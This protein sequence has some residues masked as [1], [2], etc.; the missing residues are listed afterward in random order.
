MIYTHV[1]KG[2]APRCNSPLDTL[3]PDA[4]AQKPAELE[5]PKEAAGLSL[6]ELPATQ[7]SPPNEPLPVDQALERAIWTWLKAAKDHRTNR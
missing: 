3:F 1:A 4:P 6:N 5:R 7:I 2:P